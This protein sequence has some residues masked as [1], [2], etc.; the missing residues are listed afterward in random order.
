M[1]REKFKKTSLRASVLNKMKNEIIAISF[2]E[3]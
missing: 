2:F 3:V 1:R